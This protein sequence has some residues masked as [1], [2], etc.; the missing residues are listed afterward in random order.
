[1]GT[2]N[3]RGLNDIDWHGC[4][5]HS[6]GWDDPSARALAFT[7]GGSGAEEDIH[8]MMNMYWEPLEF[9]VPQIKNRNWY[10]VVDT[11]LPA[12]EDIAEKGEEV[13]INGNKYLVSGRSV[14][15]LVSK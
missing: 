8:V 6:P 15:V 13:R 10:R 3:E 14:V 4:K 2:K 5:L 12:L 7:M 1:M 11:F 9:E